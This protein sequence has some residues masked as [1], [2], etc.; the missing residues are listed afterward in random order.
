M[1]QLVTSMPSNKIQKLAFL[2]L[3][4]LTSNLSH[5]QNHDIKHDQATD[6]WEDV[7]IKH[8]FQVGTDTWSLHKNLAPSGV[9]DSTN[10][11]NLAD[12]Q[13]K[14]SYRSTSE[15]VKADA[16]ARWANTTFRLRYD[17][18]QSVG[19]RIDELSADWSY[20]ALGVRTGVLGYKVSWCRTQDVDSPWMRE[21]D[22]FC[23]VNSTSAAIKS[24]PGIQTYI[25]AVTGSYKVQSL[26]GIYRPLF[27]NYD[28]RGF[29]EDVVSEIHIINH[30]KYGASFNAIDLNTGTEF[31]LSY[32]RSQQTANYVPPSDPTE[33]KDLVSDVGYVG[34]STYLTPAINLRLSQFRSTTNVDS[35]FPEGYIKPG[36]DLSDVFH[37][38]GRERTST[39]AELNYQQ[40]ARDVIS[41]AYSLYNVHDRYV[42]I[43]HSPPPITADQYNSY[44]Y[45]YK[46]ISKSIAWRHDWQKNIFTVIQ[47]TFSALT[48]PVDTTDTLQSHSTGR[49]LGLRLGYSF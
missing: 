15:W 8:I 36:D 31:R 18:N 27:G 42:T 45:R 4:S 37:T 49:A 14:G 10:S 32:L 11:L 9:I 44:I 21:N 23:V 1:Q 41:F 35:K 20:H 29:G 2:S 40:A 47:A 48:Q 24:A 46:I 38:F 16:E 28:T 17:Y 43:S 5:A 30:T 33:R 26:I 13:P 3:L 39:V 12:S 7:R 25:K 6:Y 22:P 19:H 34:I